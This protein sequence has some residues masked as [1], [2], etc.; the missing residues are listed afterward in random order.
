MRR[1][2]FPRGRALALVCGLLVS[3]LAAVPATAQSGRSTVRG[4]V[5]DQQGNVVTGASVTL[6]DQTKNFTRTQT[7]NGEGGY[8][9]A[10]VPPGNYR[11]EVESS[12]FKKV[13]VAEVQALVDTPVDVD[14]ELQPGLT[15]ESVTVTASNEAP[16]NTTDAT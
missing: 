15:T 11:V 5:R 1:P 8:T 3:L 7:T 10:A 12:G 2:A 6:T 4:T 9:F 14:V 16:L 13:T